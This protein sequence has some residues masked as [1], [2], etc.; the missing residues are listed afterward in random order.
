MSTF[1]LDWSATG[2]RHLA[3]VSHVLHALQACLT[4]TRFLIVVI[5]SK[6][7]ERS[8]QLVVYGAAGGPTIKSDISESGIIE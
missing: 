5:F 7:E 6:R 2:R 8:E 3:R 4:L 1:G